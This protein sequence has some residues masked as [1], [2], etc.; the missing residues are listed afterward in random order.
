M[1]KVEDAVV[2]RD[3]VSTDRNA[4]IDSYLRSNSTKGLNCLMTKKEYFRE[5]NI[6]INKLIDH[7]Q[8][9]IYLAVFSKSPA[10]IF[11]WIIATPCRN[12]VHFM[13]T[14]FPYRKT[15]MASNLFA[16]CTKNFTEV[17][18]DHIPFNVSELRKVNTKTKLVFGGKHILYTP[19]T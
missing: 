15:G 19:I 6:K 4:I 18:T 17:Y 2:I 10:V 8:T 14:K 1:E 16:R 5:Y 3:Y 11:S 12:M 13:Y 7:K 9:K